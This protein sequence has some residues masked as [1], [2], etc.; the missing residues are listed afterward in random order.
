MFAT[1][2]KSKNLVP[3]RG[4]KVKRRHESRLMRHTVEKIFLPRAG[5][6]QSNPGVPERPNAIER[7]HS[8]L[9]AHV[10]R[11][12][13]LFPHVC[14]TGRGNA[15]GYSDAA[16]GWQGSRRVSGSSSFAA[17]NA[18]P[19]PEQDAAIAALGA[20]FGLTLDRHRCFPYSR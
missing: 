1:R 18:D 20:H 14:A 11:E 8:A 17:S 5:G 10:Q 6:R 12:M 7:G 16:T 9:E 15:L 13:P 19:Y 4:R 3:Y 2:P